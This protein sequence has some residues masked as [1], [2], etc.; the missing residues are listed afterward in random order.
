[1]RAYETMYIVRP[2]VEGEALEAV[3]EKFKK[4]VEDGGGT[5]VS[6]DRW[7]KRRLA[8]PIEKE[9]EGQYIV[10]RFQAEPP[11]V[12]ELDRVFKIT[13]DVLRHIIVREDE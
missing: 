7:G 2:Q 10:M 3:V 12:Q 6:I 1:M 9:R 5:V 13:G 4:I 11:V 8:Y